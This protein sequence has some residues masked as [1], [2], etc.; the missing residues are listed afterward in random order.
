MTWRYGLNKLIVGVAMLFL[1]GGLVVMAS[2][3]TQDAEEDEIRDILRVKRAPPGQ[4]A[5]AKPGGSRAGYRTKSGDQTDR[6]SRISNSD[7]LLGLTLWRLRPS[8]RDDAL[9]IKDLIQPDGGG[10][11]QEW[12][13]ERMEADAPLRE[14][15]FVRVAIESFRAGYL[16]VIDRA[17]YHDGRYGD[18]YLIFPT[19]RIDGGHNRVEAGKIVQ[20]PGPEDKPGYFVLQRGKSKDGELQSSEELVIIIKPEP[21]ESFKTPPADR[22]LLTA[23]SVVALIT[24]YSTPLMHSELNGG[25]GQ[26][27]TPA[28]VKAARDRTRRLTEVDPLPQSVFRARIKASDPM[29]VRMV[30]KVGA[31]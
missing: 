7:S 8:T 2:W 15:Q 27:I 12:T 6:S 10:P 9:E 20:I 14:G 16:Y 22:K 5:V 4:K 3:L 23:Q 17:K 29:L 24:K 30:L 21:F 26:P 28:E 19:Q 13:P 18:P 31:K 11:V 25:A 1:G